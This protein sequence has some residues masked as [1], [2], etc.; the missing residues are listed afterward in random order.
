[1]NEVINDGG[2]TCS[3]EAE[4]DEERCHDKV[5][6]LDDGDPCEGRLWRFHLYS[7]G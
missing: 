6:I 1:M 5:E 7:P 4:D 3:S 2:W